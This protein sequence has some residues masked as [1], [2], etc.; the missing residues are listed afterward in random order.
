VTDVS[1][2]KVKLVAPKLIAV[3]PTVSD[4]LVSAELGML[5]RVLVDPLIDLLVKVCV[6]VKVAT[7][8]SI[9]MVTAD[10]PL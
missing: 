4:E 2:A 7:V 3:D 1:P 10:E 9:A 5:V 8:E 6:P